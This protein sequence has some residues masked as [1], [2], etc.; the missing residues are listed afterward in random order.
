ML[1]YREP[2]TFDFSLENFVAA[3]EPDESGKDKFV[4]K[5]QFFTNSLIYR[6]TNKFYDDEIASKKGGKTPDKP[7][8][9]FFVKDRF[10]NYYGD[11]QHLHALDYLMDV[12]WQAKHMV[13]GDYN[14]GYVD[15]WD[16]GELIKETFDVDWAYNLFLIKDRKFY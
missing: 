16:E 10:N 12:L 5:D 3:Y 8:L 11:E 1:I 15:E 13:Y 2:C 7:W 14:F 4:W 9:L 6:V